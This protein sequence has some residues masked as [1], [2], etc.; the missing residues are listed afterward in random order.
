MS[1]IA[2]VTMVYN[3]PDFLP[4]WVRHY[5][6][7]VGK[8][9]CFIIDHGSDDGSTEAIDRAVN[10]IRLPRSPQDDIY[11]VE[12]VSNL[13][14]ELLTR[15]RYVV[16]SDVDE[17]IF[18]D[19]RQYSSML[20]F[21]ESMNVDVVTAFGFDVLHMR[22]TEPPLD[23]G[24]RILEQRQWVRFNSPMCKPVLVQ[25]PVRWAPGFHCTDD[26]IIFGGLFLFHLRWADLDL[27]LRRLQKTRSQDWADPNAGLWQRNSDSD[28]Y[29][30][31]CDL[32]NAPLNEGC[33]FSASDP[34]LKAAAEYVLA[35]RSGREQNTFKIDLDVWAHDIWRVPKALKSVF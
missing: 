27:A 7:L 19:P 8:Q 32:T 18:P 3:E 10:L 5:S 23:L 6:N 26:D 25:K 30:Y 1:K 22:E 24:R 14:K 11:R 28:H 29:K 31:L 12:A 34:R 4:I 20:S 17:I 13:V 35:T 15:Y 2:A 16:H 33:S 21:C 9:N